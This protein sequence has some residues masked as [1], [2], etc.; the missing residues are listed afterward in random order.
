V[1]P[2]GA[3]LI[4][5]PD[6]AWYHVVHADASRSEIL[7]SFECPVPAYADLETIAATIRTAVLGGRGAEAL[8]WKVGVDPRTHHVRSVTLWW[9]PESPLT[10]EADEGPRVV[11]GE[12][13]DGGG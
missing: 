13:L 4:G 9:C 11:V 8:G 10:V 12:V 3:G 5:N 2:I 7:A 6:V 1:I